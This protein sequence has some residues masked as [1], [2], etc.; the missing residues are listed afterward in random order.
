L[1]RLDV[2][3]IILRQQNNP[4][5]N[6]VKHTH[7]ISRRALTSFSKLAYSLRSCMVTKTFHEHRSVRPTAT[8]HPVT[9]STIH[10]TSDEGGQTANGY[11]A[12]IITQQIDDYMLNRAPNPSIRT[13]RN[14]KTNFYRAMLCIRGT[15]HGPSVRLCPSVCLS[16]VGVL[17]KRL[18]TGSHKQHHTIAQGL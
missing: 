3:L 14:F 5:N 8:M 4:E 10:I 16:Q 7:T 18:N 12:V 2:V 1:T 17:L 11:H 13:V 15:S 6:S 9:A